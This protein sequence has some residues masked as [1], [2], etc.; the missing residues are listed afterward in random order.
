MNSVDLFKD[1]RICTQCQH[2]ADKHHNVV[3]KDGV[4]RIFCK[5]CP[6]TSMRLMGDEGR[7][8]PIPY[9]IQ[10]PIGPPNPCFEE[11]PAST[12]SENFLPLSVKPA[13]ALQVKFHGKAWPVDEIEQL[14][15]GDQIRGSLNYKLQLYWDQEGL[16]PGCGTRI[17]FDSM[18]MDR[19]TAGADD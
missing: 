2:N 18:E 7:E 15:Y 1:D 16:C 3:G 8:N 6:R 11:K 12:R 14:R 9:F 10:G 5:D 19:L 13:N 17:R 4:L